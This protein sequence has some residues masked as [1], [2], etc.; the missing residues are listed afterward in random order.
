MQPQ[1]RQHTK[2]IVEAVWD[3]VACLKGLESWLA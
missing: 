1:A 2:H 3:I